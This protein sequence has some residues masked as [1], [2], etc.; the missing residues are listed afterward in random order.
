VRICAQRYVWYVGCENVNVGCENMHVGCEEYLRYVGCGN[1][2][3]FNRKSAQRCVG[4]E[5]LCVV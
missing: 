3:P 2:S 1:M 5:S 4:C